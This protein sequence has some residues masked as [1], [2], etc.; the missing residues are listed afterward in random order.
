M[1]ISQ[2]E[3]DATLNDNSF[4]DF[5]FDNFVAYGIQKMSVKSLGKTASTIK[6]FYSLNSKLENH[7]PTYDI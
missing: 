3:K 1:T 6:K 4:A 5:T 7:P 2:D